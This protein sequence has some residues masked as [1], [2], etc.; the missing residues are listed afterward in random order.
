MY[1]DKSPWY[2]LS[3][4]H[5]MNH[6]KWNAQ[7]DLTA[8]LRCCGLAL[9]GNKGPWCH[10]NT[11][12]PAGA[13]RRMERNRQKLM[14]Q[15]KGSLTE[16]WMKW[17]ITTTVLIRQIYKTKSEVHR[18]TLTTQIPVH[19][20]KPLQGLSLK[21]FCKLETIGSLFKWQ[22]SQIWDCRW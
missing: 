1:S 14:G 12:P 9:V 13:G 18:G 8:L 2:L 4:V 17:R 20:S 21:Q 11:S 19:S 3:A 5:Q 10:S 15:D 16:L 7:D 6:A 22:V